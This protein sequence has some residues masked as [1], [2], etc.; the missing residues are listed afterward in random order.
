MGNN[1]LLF[2]GI[3]IGIIAYVALYIGKGIQ[4]YAIEGFKEDKT[5]K[6]KHSGIWI[7]G[8]ILTASFVFIQW[9]PL[10]LFHTPMNLIAPLEG[11]G[12]ITLLV[13]SIFF[14]KEK[15]STLELFGVILI[16]AG[17]VLI[18]LVA[19]TPEELQRV[20]LNLKAFWICL[21][22]T[23]GIS[24]IAFLLVFRLS[25][26]LTGVILGLA[27]GSFMAFQTLAK[28]ITD[29]NSL[30]LIFTFVTF[31]FAIL[32]LGFTQ[33]ALAKTRANI[34][35]PC[36][37]SASISLTTLL[38]IFVIDEIIYPIQIIGIVCIIIGII[39]MNIYLSRTGEKKVAEEEASLQIDLEQDET[40]P[41][42]VH[43]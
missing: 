10:T 29:I 20:A 17:T 7:F 11:I 33:L 1:L 25:D 22:I 35:I 40:K 43:N 27:A 26:T 6:S 31:L 37:T 8:T 38:G 41:K 5:V 13:F 32:T 4:K 16:I 36:F 21:G 3:L 34:V 28:R 18:N 24:L 42:E 14:L 2:F 39:G 19:V 9:I 30:A 15:I 12:L 23:S